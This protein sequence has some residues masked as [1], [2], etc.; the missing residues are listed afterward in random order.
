[1]KCLLCHR[2]IAPGMAWDKRAECQRHPDGTEHVYG[3]GLGEGPCG[4][5]PPGSVLVW[6]QHSKCYH[7]AGR[8]VERGH[9]AVAG[10]NLAMTALY[11]EGEDA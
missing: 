2:R 7:V 3:A 10:S 9:D 11:E 4:S 5:E 6:T 1:M 8:R